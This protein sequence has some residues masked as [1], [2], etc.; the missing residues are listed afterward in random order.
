MDWSFNPSDLILSI[1]IAGL[2]SIGVLWN[3][4]R[5]DRGLQPQEK[6][7]KNASKEKKQSKKGS[8]EQASSQ[9]IGERVRSE[10]K[11]HKVPPAHGHPKTHTDGELSTAKEIDF[12]YPVDSKDHL[13]MDESTLHHVSSLEPD[14]ETSMMVRSHARIRDTDILT[15]T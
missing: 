5:R 11:P 10:E 6:K 14:N 13:Y 2:A 12:L 4:A 7:K 9:S 15:S 3:C 1:L 8:T